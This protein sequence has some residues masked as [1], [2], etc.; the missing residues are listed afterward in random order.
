MRQIAGLMITFMFRFNRSV[1]RT[2]AHALGDPLEI[3]TAYYDLL[4]TGREL[5][6]PM[7]IMN[8]FENDIIR[9]AS[10]SQK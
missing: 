5:G 2:S 6:L 3:K 10:S 9:F 1:Q 8:S 4:Y 7:P